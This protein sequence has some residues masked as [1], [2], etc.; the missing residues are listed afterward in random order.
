MKTTLLLSLLA[1]FTLGSCRGGGGPATRIG[2]GI[3]HGVYKTGSV[4][5]RVGRSIE[6]AAR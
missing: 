2:R 6:N 5:K 4:V 1:L 3:D